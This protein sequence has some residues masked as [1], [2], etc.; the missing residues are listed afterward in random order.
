LELRQARLVPPI[1]STGLA[2]PWQRKCRAAFE[3]VP[4]KRNFNMKHLRKRT[5]TRNVPESRPFDRRSRTK[6]LA[7]QLMRD[8]SERA[9]RKAARNRTAVKIERVKFDPFESARW[10]VVAGGN[11]G[12]VAPPMSKAKTGFRIECRACQREF[13]SVGW[14]YC[15]TCKALPIDERRTP[16]KTGRPCE[17]PDCTRKIPRWRNGRE[18]RKDVRFC[19]RRCRDAAAK[20]GHKTAAKLPTYLTRRFTSDQGKE[21]PINGPLLIGPKTM[22][23][24]LRNLPE[25]IAAGCP[26]AEVEEVREV[27]LGTSSKIA[28]KQK[29]PW[30]DDLDIP[31]WLRRA[32]GGAAS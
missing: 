16:L 8:R 19:S 32:P 26:V 3:R 11:P 9:A 17:R 27:P 22:P 25:W 20:I 29:G 15:P 7:E 23:P 4:G 14:A 28:F 2:G 6:R 12:H 21:T 13:E 18:V 5:T 24:L 31:D 10:R 30:S 1:S